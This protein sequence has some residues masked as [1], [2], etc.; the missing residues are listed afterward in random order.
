MSNYKEENVISEK[1][2]FR[3]LTNLNFHMQATSE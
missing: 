2:I 3:A 1:F